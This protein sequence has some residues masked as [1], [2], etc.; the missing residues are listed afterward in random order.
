MDEIIIMNKFEKIILTD[1]Q[2]FFSEY[3]RTYNEAW[4]KA[5]RLN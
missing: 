5:S 3:R 4:I 1:Y 2:H